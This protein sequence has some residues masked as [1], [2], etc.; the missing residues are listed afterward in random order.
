MDDGANGLA[1]KMTSTML[2][3]V[4]RFSGYR[5]SSEIKG[6]TSWWYHCMRMG[7]HAPVKLAPHQVVLVLTYSKFDTYKCSF[8]LGY[9]HPNYMYTY[10]DL[11]PKHAPLQFSPHQTVTFA[12]TYSDT[13]SPTTHSFFERRTSE[14]VRIPF[15]GIER[16]R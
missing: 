11:T 8:A 9:A 3:E 5:W 14:R 6:S 4:S 16:I 7:R 10:L 2:R 15:S 13:R 12:L 1:T